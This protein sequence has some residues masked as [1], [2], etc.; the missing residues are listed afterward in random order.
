ATAASAAKRSA[1][2]V[3]P[4]LLAHH[5]FGDSGAQVV[6]QTVGERDDHVVDASVFD[7]LAKQAPSFWAVIVPKEIANHVQG[8]IAREIDYRVIEQVGD[9]LFHRDTSKGG[10]NRGGLSDQRKM[11]AHA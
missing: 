1:L 5:L 4:D 2:A 10:V 8:E 11:T 7:Q 9:Q 3:Q 6:L